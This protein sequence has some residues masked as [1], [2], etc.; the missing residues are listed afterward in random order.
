M[1][2]LNDNAHPLESLLQ[3]HCPNGVEFKELG[4]L[5]EINGGKLN[6]NKAQAKGLYEFFTYDYNNPKFVD[7]YAWDTE[8]LIICKKDNGENPCRY[9]NGKFNAF[10]WMRILHSF[11]NEANIHY[12]KYYFNAIFMQ[13]LQT[14]SI[15]ISLPYIAIETIKKFQIP[16]PPLEIQ[17]KIVEILDAFTELKAELEAEL[18]ARLKQYEYYRNK[19][20]S[21]DELE[22]R[23]VKLNEILK[24]K[25]LGEL[26][27]RN[28]G[29]K[30]TAHQMQALHKENALIRIFA[31]GSTIADVDYRDLPKKDVIDKP[32]IICK[33]RGYIGF[34]YYDKP[35]SHK[36]EF[37]SYTI[38]KNTNQKFIYYF[39]VNQQEYFQQIAK[40]N[41]VKIP[42][43]KVKNTDNFQI[44]LPPLEVQ[45]EIVEIL[46]KFD[47]LTNDLTSGIPA[48]IEARKKQYEYYRERLLSF[49][50]KD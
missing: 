12:I 36:S 5:C 48:E 8:A 37:W 30:I 13:F 39:L 35:F 34:E 38:E 11:K 33:A 43:L 31:G 3:Q 18:E 4:E 50:V 1:K 25:T 15:N 41:S 32:S 24:F 9:F 23:T 7:N 49:I 46:D 22:N 27:I 47:T 44:P 28:A 20:L 16:L 29:T 45:N 17:Y 26:G 10:Q 19:L 21:H 42:Q 40:A 6:A 14:N 2:T